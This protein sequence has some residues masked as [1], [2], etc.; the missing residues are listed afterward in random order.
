MVSREREKDMN[1]K[2]LAKRLQKLGYTIR[3]GVSGNWIIGSQH[4][5]YVWTFPTLEG[6]NRFVEDEESWTN[7]GAKRVSLS[8]L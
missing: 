2:S 3:R 5:T 7:Y 4:I 8:D 1:S 6:V